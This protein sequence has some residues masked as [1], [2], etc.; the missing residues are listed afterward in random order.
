MELDDVVEVLRRSR[1]LYATER[2][3]QDAVEDALTGAG[4]LVEREVPLSSYS[5]IDF[6]VGDVGIEC[7]ISG[8]WRSVARQLERYAAFDRIGSLL[9]VTTRNLHSN[10]PL[11]MSGKPIW[12]HRIGSVL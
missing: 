3:L 8:A 12:V 7:K 5:R 4:L 10:V 6:V 11:T 1:I 9:L 2:D